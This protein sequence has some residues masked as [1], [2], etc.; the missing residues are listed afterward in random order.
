MN[1]TDLGSY[2]TWN[3]LLNDLQV[4]DLLGSFNNSLLLGSSP[5]SNQRL[6]SGWIMG[7]LRESQLQQ[8]WVNC[9]DAALNVKAYS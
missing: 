1:T 9:T 5:Y 7:H 8:F 2:V 4:L 3:I 6:V